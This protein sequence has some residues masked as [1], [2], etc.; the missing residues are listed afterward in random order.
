MMMVEFVSTTSFLGMIG[1]LSISWCGE[2][3]NHP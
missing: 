2:S 1:I 3:G